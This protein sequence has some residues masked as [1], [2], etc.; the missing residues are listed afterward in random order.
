MPE[1]ES[2]KK[3]LLKVL[4]GNKSDLED[5]KNFVIKTADAMKKRNSTKSKYYFKIS[6]WTQKNDDKD[7]ANCYLKITED[8]LKEKI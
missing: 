1:K 4:I 6:C 8:I 2:S 5:S 3:P 7:F